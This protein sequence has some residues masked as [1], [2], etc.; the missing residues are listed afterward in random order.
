MSKRGI[1]HGDKRENMGTHLLIVESPAKAKTI[2]K[3]LG[4]DFTV[5]SSVG[6][7]RD[8][9]KSDKAIAIEKDGES[10]WSFEPKYEISE[11]KTKVISDLK[12]AVKKADDIYLAS[13]PDREGEAIAWHLKQVLEPVAGKKPFRRVTYNQ[14]TK[15]AGLKA[16]GEAW[17]MDSS[18]K[19]AT[20]PASTKVIERNSFRNCKLLKLVEFAD[21]S[22]LAKIGE[23][24][25]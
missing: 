14:I 13:D 19:S 12:A 18:I 25:F 11:G 5:K 8:L 24:S 16:V 21:G 22:R 2:G 1:L 15:A 10:H 7:I 3:Y 17:F 6:H 4:S 23:H 20:I 9:P